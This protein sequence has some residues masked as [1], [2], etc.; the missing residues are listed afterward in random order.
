MTKRPPPRYYGVRTYR[1]P[2]GRFSFQYPS[3]WHVFELEENR[4]GLMVSPE[5]ENPQTWFSVWISQLEL[6]VVAEDLED[7]KDG[8]DE[9]L[10]QL[11]EIK[12][13][14]ASEE[15]LNSLIKFERIYTFREGDMIRKRKSWLLYV[16]T[17]LMVVT[18]QGANEEEYAY[19][20]PMGN[21]SFFRF[22]LPE[23]L[24]FATDRDLSGQLR[25]DPPA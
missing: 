21:Y 12:V 7:L 3:D 11:P 9:G 24:W 16:D 14:S 18:Y 13:E 5:A 15:T 4:D 23:A 8:V 20:L 6:N 25:S 2:H 19:W 10:S 22:E 17:W 1:D